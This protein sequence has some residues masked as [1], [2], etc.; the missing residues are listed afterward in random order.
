MKIKDIPKI[1]RP[2]EK[3]LKYGFDKISN[4]EL[5]AILLRNGTKGISSIELAY[6]ILKL[7]NGLKGLKNISINELNKIK[8]IN[9]VKSIQLLAAIELS[10]RIN[11]DIE[12]NQKINDGLDVYDLVGDL[13]KY[14]EQEHF[15]LIFLDIKN[16]LISYKF[17]YKGGLNFHFVHMRDIFREVV[18][19]N[20]Y[21][22]IC[23]HNH[24][25]G[26]PFPSKS[27]YDTTMNILE[28]SNMMGIKFEDHIII[29]N[30]CYYSFK[31]SSNIFNNK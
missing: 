24:P 12:I 22:F 30:N 19:N 25:T 17:L 14:E 3:A 6:E 26:D 20:A 4:S 10:K 27:D 5:L 15:I 1:D 9:N 11:D 28:N 29:G 7:T 23:V 16:N 18:R 13:I 8:G 31:E 2:R 21:K